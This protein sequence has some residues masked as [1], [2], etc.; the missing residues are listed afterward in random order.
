MATYDFSK[1]ITFSNAG[2]GGQYG[3]VDGLPVLD[4]SVADQLISQF[5]GYV[6]GDAAGRADNAMGWDTGSIGGVLTNG[7]GVFG[8]RK[9]PVMQY[10]DN[11]G[12]PTGEYTYSGDMEAAAKQLGI[13]TSQ[14]KD[15]YETKE[16]PGIFG[17]LQK[18][19]VLTKS[20]QDQLYDAIN[21]A[22]KD[23]Y[24]VAGKTGYQAGGIGENGQTAA[25]PGATKN[26][27]AVLYKKEGNALIPL[28]ATAQYFNAEMELDPGSF[29]GDLAGSFGPIAA[30]AAMA[31]GHPEIAAAISAATSVATGGDIDDA[32]KAA[33]LTYGPSQIVP[34]LSAE[35]GS[36]TGLGVDASRAIASGLVGTGTSIANG[37]D[38]DEA[39][40]RGTIGG[41]TGYAGNSFFGPGGDAGSA[42]STTGDLGEHLQVFD[43]GST[44][45]SNSDWM[46]ISGTDIF[47]NAFNVG[48]NGIGL[49]E[50]G[51]QLGGT[52]EINFG[53]SLADPTD[54]Q[55]LLRYNV[56]N[57][58]PI[59]PGMGKTA[60][61][62]V[63][64]FLQGLIS[65][66][67][68]VSGLNQTA[69]K[70]TN[71]DAA[72]SGL[73]Q[74]DN[75]SFSA[76]PT[77]GTT[78]A[79]GTTGS[80]TGSTTLAGMALPDIATLQSTTLK[81]MVAGETQTASNKTPGVIGGLEDPS[82]TTAEGG[83]FKGNKIRLYGE[84]VTAKDGG[85]MVEGENGQPVEHSPEFFSEGG[86]KNTYVKGAGDG[87]SDEVP[88]MLANGEFVIPADVVSG[89]GNG[90]N[91]SGAKVL[92]EF[93]K[94][95]RSHK[96]KADAASLPEDSKGP[97]AYLLEAKK[98][99]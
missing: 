62:A 46:P 67:N 24:L 3:Y 54:V 79:T 47:G 86:L 56:A 28:P 31:T 21:N 85:I 19:E 15:V 70:N 40:L 57:T 36:A 48:A 42:L 11:G 78:G 17:I 58:T 93:L 53:G 12:T 92:D 38:L 13:D 84:P 7:A 22:A 1:P 25:I 6:Q 72:N 68:K 90:S 32:L 8:V 5:N 96:R 39:I 34:G 60:S 71:T 49:Y 18:Q 52:P 94:V 74:L 76:L 55:N 41:T 29:L 9:E 66:G 95:I 51:S 63:N 97:L 99:V 10:D 77:T 61:S 14:F 65:S 35:I 26:H 88:A 87:T 43:D 81:P 33:A 80:S 50:D 89:L 82:Q 30:I 44:L 23:I 69:L 2:A 4:A 83:V 16:V 98:K 73:S 64:K 75:I 91:D 27:A 37:A 20:A 45:L 59:D